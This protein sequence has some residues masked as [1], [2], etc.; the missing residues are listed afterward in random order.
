MKTIR[1]AKDRTASMP[2]AVLAGY[3]PLESRKTRHF[4]LKMSCLPRLEG[5][6]A[7]L[8][9]ARMQFDIRLI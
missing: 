3:W 1:A 9:M 4:V 5:L 2:L 7:P 8:Q 6:V